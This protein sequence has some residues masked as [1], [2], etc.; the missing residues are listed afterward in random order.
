MKNKVLTMVA[1]LLLL[2]N[3][4]AWAHQY[5]R[6]PEAFYKERRNDGDGCFSFYFYNPDM[7][8]YAISSGYER[9]SCHLGAGYL[10]GY[11]YE[12]V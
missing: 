3:A 11:D 8:L 1:I 12:R 5:R 4:M 10:L 9:K 2:P 6:K 7:K